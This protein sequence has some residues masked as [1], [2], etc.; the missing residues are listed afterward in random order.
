MTFSLQYGDNS[1]ASN[2]TTTWVRFSSLLNS[3]P[4]ATCLVYYDRLR[5]M[6][7]L[8]SNDGTTWMPGTPGSGEVLENRQ[9][10]ITL[11]ASS[12]SVSG[13]T[14]TLNLAMNFRSRFAGSRNIYM[15]AANV[16]GTNS[17]WQQRG[18]WIVP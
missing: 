6:L 1:G 12:V 8:L 14:L 7:H 15:F 5:H 10:S 9:C 2:L 18:S 11:N 3:D 13:T 17:G 16:G 4:T